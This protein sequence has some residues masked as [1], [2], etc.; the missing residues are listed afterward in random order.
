MPVSTRSRWPART[1]PT[2]AKAGSVLSRSTVRPTEVTDA[3]SAIAGGVERVA[4]RDAHEVRV[5]GERPGTAQPVGPRVHERR[6]QA[7]QDDERERAGAEL[8]ERDRQGQRTPSED[9]HADREPEPRC[10]RPADREQELGPL[11]GGLVAGEVEH[12]RGRRCE[13]DPG[14]DDPD[15]E[16]GVDVRS[17][18]D[19]ARGRRAEPEERAQR[20]PRP[21]GRGRCAGPT[22]SRRRR[23]PCPRSGARGPSTGPSSRSGVS[24][25]FPHSFHEPS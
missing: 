7:G 8:A 20:L 24:E 2:A 1:A 23:A 12:R 17:R 19:D 11:A 15:H 5:P 13:H 16:P 25:R 4:S 18:R 6:D 10:V 3:G 22:R 21:A 9:D 14:G